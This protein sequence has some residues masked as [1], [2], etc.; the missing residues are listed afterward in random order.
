MRVLKV[1]GFSLVGLVATY[2]M[3]A[4]GAVLWPARIFS[5]QAAPTAA[6]FASRQRASGVRTEQVYPYQEQRFIARDG[7][8]LYARVFGKPAE[9][10]IVLLHGV[11]SDSSA[12]NDSA[13]QI[14]A[15]T[16]SQAIA[17]DLRGHGHSGG[18]PWQVT[19]AG[20]YED[21]VADVIKV[22]RAAQ[23]NGKII[24]AGHSMGGGIALRYALNPT[25]PAPDAYLLFAPLLGGNSPTGRNAAPPSAA[26]GNTV[27]FRTARLIGA[28]MLNLVGVHAFDKLP[29][30]YFNQPRAPAYGFAAL[31]SMQPNAPRDYCSALSAI[32]VPLLVVVGSKDEAFNALA[33]ADVLRANGHPESTQIIDGSTH[34][35]V[36]SDSRTIDIVSQWISRI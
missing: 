17:L 12:M 8:Q 15:A 4:I 34:N 32:R 24:L 14:H 7:V 19:Y 6:E 35:R 11:T 25:A 10:T 13:G 5:N 36:L 22:L 28:L 20:Q 27:Y 30:L 21:D 16:G 23:P 29:I 26:Q 33:Y 9:R 18:M 31:Q 3:V 2:F 1:I